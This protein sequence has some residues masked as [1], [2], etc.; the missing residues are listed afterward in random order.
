MSKHQLAFAEVASSIFSFFSLLSLAQLF[1]FNKYN[2]LKNNKL[3]LVFIRKVRIYA[4]SMQ[5]KMKM[6]AKFQS[7]FV[8]NS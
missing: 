8:E 4:Y 7:F 2:Y 1:L 6:L 5:H 3:G